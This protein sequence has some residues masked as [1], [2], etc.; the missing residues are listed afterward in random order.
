VSKNILSRFV[1]LAVL[2]VLSLGAA[3]PITAQDVPQSDPSAPIRV[4]VDAE[5]ARQVQ[6][7]IDANPDKA[8]LIEIIN[9]PL[10][11]NVQQR[12]LLY[13][14][15]GGNW[16]DVIFEDPSTWRTLNTPAFDFF[17]ADL[18]PYIPQD[19]LDQ[20]YPTANDPCIAPDGSLICVRNDIA[21]EV[22]FYNVPAM[23]EFGYELPT[24][25]EEYV[26]LAQQVAEDHPGYTMGQLD[27]WE[28]QLLWYYHSDCPI[29]QPLS[30]SSFRVNFLHPNCQ[31]MSEMLDTVNALGVLDHQGTFS[32]GY[33]QIWEQGNW[34]IHF[35]PS[36]LPDFVIKGLYLN[37][38]DPENQGTVG[39]ALLP[40]WADQTD[41]TTSNVGGGSYAMSR[42]TLNAEL[43]AELILFVSTNPDVGAAQ[44]ATPA[45]RPSAA[46]WGANL[47]T[48]VPLLAS[49]PDPWTVI[50]EAA[51]GVL[52]DGA[53]EGPP[54]SSP[55]FSPFFTDIAAGNRTVVSIS[56][57]LQA[58][59]V[60]AVTTAGFESVTDGP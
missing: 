15:I 44:A 7:F 47:L 50:S 37:A 1:M 24:T 18:R 21:P 5:R 32:A 34:L 12:M 22:M 26:A 13:N 31:R 17:P 30:A 16:P 33:G 54:R 11:A 38:D 8:S 3:L 58:G 60:E 27:G 36:W 25:W 57:E 59:L 51:S 40:N 10:G 39:V 52:A 56:E 43:A 19:V 4:W 48:R 23:A 29:M 20:F 28:P 49:D 53:V 6:A 42:H 41:R 2:V 55:V 46:L 9:E 35:G 45:Y 14:N